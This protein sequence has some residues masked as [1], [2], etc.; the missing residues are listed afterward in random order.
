MSLTA[1]DDSINVFFNLD[2]YLELTAGGNNSLVRIR[3][4]EEE[5]EKGKNE[6]ERDRKR[7]REMICIIP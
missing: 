2:Y 5:K 7:R 6:R 4:K 3:D 1:E